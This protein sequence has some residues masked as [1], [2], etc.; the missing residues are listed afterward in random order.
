MFYMFMPVEKNE[1]FVLDDEEEE[2]AEIALR[3]EEFE[4]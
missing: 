3:E 1:Y 4:L 2:A